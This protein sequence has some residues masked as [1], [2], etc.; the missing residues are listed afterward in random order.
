[1][2]SQT[3]NQMNISPKKL[4]LFDAI[5]ALISSVMLGIILAYIQP[6]VGMPK[7]I[8]Y[9]LAGI[10][11]VFFIYSSFCF[12]FIKKNIKSFLIGIALANFGYC[13]LSLIFMYNNFDLLTTLGITYFV[14]E[15]VIVI[16]LASVEFKTALK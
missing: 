11:F 4:F 2:I 9:L 13:I 10:A 8:L 7:S 6:L 14:L 15:K 1:M 12:L 16:A 3:V 5:G